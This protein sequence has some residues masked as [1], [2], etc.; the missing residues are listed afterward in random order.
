[1]VAVG[2]VVANN[3]TDS[4]TGGGDEQEDDE[5]ADAEQM[6]EAGVT[7]RCW[8]LHVGLLLDVLRRVPAAA[9]DSLVVVEHVAL[10]CLGVLAALCLDGVEY[11]SFE[12]DGAAVPVTGGGAERDDK[13]RVS[14]VKLDEVVL[15]EILRASA[16]S[17]SSLPELPFPAPT[18]GWG[19]GGGGVE[20]TTPSQARN[21][22]LALRARQGTVSGSGVPAPDGGSLV[23]P[24]EGLR[25]GMAPASPSSRFPEH[26][27]LRLMTGR[28]SA[29]LRRFADMV[30]GALAAT[31]GPAGSEDMAEV[32]AHLLGCV[33]AEGSEAAALQVGKWKRGL[34]LFS[35]SACCRLTLSVR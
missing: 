23:G 10:P 31:K 34:F 8:R 35:D 11:P 30:L 21:A 9:E 19:G 20:W 24:T 15:D 14:G 5:D 4:N 3:A 29:V 22:H 25:A 1:M 18:T 26:W 6:M 2:S 16:S 28:Q 27:L 12:E 32:A 17:W 33:G 7:A 13:R